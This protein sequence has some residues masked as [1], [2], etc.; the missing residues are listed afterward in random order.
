MSNQVTHK[1]GG[2]LTF[3]Q[4]VAYI[5]HELAKFEQ[6]DCPLEHFFAPGVY[7]RSI[8]MPSGSIVIGKI[9]RTEHLNIIEQGSVM[10]IG[11]DGSREI[12]SAPCTFVSK[13][14]VQKVLQILEDC[15][16]KTVHV[17]ATNETDIPTLEAMLAEPIPDAPQIEEGRDIEDLSL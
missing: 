6:I 7:V 12:L 14:G 16:W 10:L 1:D 2:E 4:K 3:K 17:N 11:E 15:R 8:F 5:G 13:A 9:H